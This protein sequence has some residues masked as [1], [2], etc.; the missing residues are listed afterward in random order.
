MVWLIGLAIL[1]YYL[2]FLSILMRKGKKKPE[3]I[4]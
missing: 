3:P 2:H 1:T 4:S